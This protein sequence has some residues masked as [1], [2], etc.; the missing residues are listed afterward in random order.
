MTKLV[1]GCKAK[2]GPSGFAGI[3]TSRHEDFTGY[4]QWG[5]QPKVDPKKPAECPDVMAFDETQI[6]VVSGGKSKS[7]QFPPLPFKLGDD[8]ED[9]ASGYRGVAMARADFLNGCTRI[10]VHGKAKPGEAPPERKNFMLQ[11]LKKVGDGLN[12]PA[13]A[14]DQPQA[15]RGKGGP[16]QKVERF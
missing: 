1:L 7:Q 14:P 8:V 16:P 11:L 5:I 15:N 12:T 10:V 3:V 6:V 4:V 2:D 13:K 9:Q